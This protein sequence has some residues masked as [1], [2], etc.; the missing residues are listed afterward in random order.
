MSLTIKNIDLGATTKP[1]FAKRILNMFLEDDKTILVPANWSYSSHS[2]EP[3]FTGLKSES[4]EKIKTA[5]IKAVTQHSADALASVFKE[6][7]TLK[8]SLKNKNVPIPGGKDATTLD[9]WITDAVVNGLAY[10]FRT[11]ATAIYRTFLSAQSLPKEFVEV[12]LSPATCAGIAK[13]VESVWRKLTRVVS[14][15]EI[16]GDNALQIKNGFV[17]NADLMLSMWDE[18]NAPQIPLQRGY[19]FYKFLER[20][21]P[22]DDEVRDIFKLKLGSTMSVEFS[23]PDM[24]LNDLIKDAVALDASMRYGLPG[25]TETKGNISQLLHEMGIQQDFLPGKGKVDSFSVLTRLLIYYEYFNQIMNNGTRN[26]MMERFLVIL[27]EF[28]KYDP[29][30][31]QPLTKKLKGTFIAYETLFKVRKFLFSLVEEHYKFTT[32][33]EISHYYPIVMD[34]FYEEHNALK[35]FS[36]Y[37]EAQKEKEKKL[38]YMP[39]ASEVAKL[40]LLSFADEFPTLEIPEATRLNMVTIFH[41]EEFS[42]DSFHPSPDFSEYWKIRCS[43]KF[44]SELLN[45]TEWPGPAAKKVIKRVTRKR[46]KAIPPLG[47]LFSESFFVMLG[48]KLYQGEEYAL[49]LLQNDLMEIMIAENISQLATKLMLPEELVSEAMKQKDIKLPATLL[50]PRSYYL[51]MDWTEETANDRIITDSKSLISGARGLAPDSA[52]L[53]TAGY[54]ESSYGSATSIAL[55]KAAMVAIPVIDPPIAIKPVEKPVSSV[56]PP[57]AAEIE[58]LRLQAEEEAAAAAKK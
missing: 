26:V 17:K 54:K 2:F 34:S 51:V 9:A 5:M 22:K 42:K 16:I 44:D 36:R 47:S 12:E 18:I 52:I 55:R 27:Q 38:V 37:Y 4:A 53:M 30:S 58:K 35:R 56:I 1:N 39:A 45:Y 8:A 20:M 10:Q 13:G 23:F 11:E 29:Q 19:A 46:I 15:N 14:I 57:D 50:L 21:T 40:R 33:G 25:L 48:I 32:T 7:N 43:E 24:D 41:N 31:K 3:S 6:L 28:T 49:S